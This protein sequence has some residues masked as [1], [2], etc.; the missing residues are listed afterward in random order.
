MFGFRI[1]TWIHDG[2]RD[3]PRVASYSFYCLEGGTDMRFKIHTSSTAH[4]DSRRI[5]EARE[6]K[7]GF[8][9][10]FFGALVVL[11]A[12]V[13][14]TAV[15]P[16][17]LRFPIGQTGMEPHSQHFHVIIDR[18]SQIKPREEWRTR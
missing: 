5:L 4:E 18:S 17:P 7:Y 3:R 15:R 11:P 1:Q 9:P 10:Y 12:A 13:S 2:N 8:W 14:Y 6:R 16:S